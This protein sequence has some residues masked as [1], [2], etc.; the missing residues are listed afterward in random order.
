MIDVRKYGQNSV[1]AF[2]LVGISDELTLRTIIHIIE[3]ISLIMNFMSGTHLVFVKF[4]NVHT[5][6]FSNFFID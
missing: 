3:L 4:V 1:K 6:S 5:V 2:W